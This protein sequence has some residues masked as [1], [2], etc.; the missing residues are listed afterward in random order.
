M[1]IDQVASR[2]LLRQTGANPSSVI[3]ESFVPRGACSSITS[4]SAANHLPASAPT[5]AVDPIHGRRESH[6]TRI[7]APTMLHQHKR[8]VPQLPKAPMES[9]SR[10]RCTARHVVRTEMNNSQ[11]LLSITVRFRMLDPSSS[12]LSRAVASDAVI[13]Y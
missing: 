2:K 1:E 12:I 10:P 9:V 6:H 11:G 5:Y 3:A 4:E 13:N 8:L 7:V